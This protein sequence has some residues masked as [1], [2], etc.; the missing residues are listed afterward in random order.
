MRL[1]SARARLPALVAGLLL[2]AAPASACNVP[3]FRYALERWTTDPY[4]VIVFHRGPLGPADKALTDA[5]AKHADADP[6][7]VNF[8]L[9]LIDLNRDLPAEIV[10]LYEAQPVQDLPLMVV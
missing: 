5:L 4:E 2:T 10:K 9:D 7:A 6:A 1:S 3:V 8:S